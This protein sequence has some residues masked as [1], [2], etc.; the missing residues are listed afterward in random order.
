MTFIVPIPQSYIDTN[1][2]WT[3]ASGL[4]YIGISTNTTGYNYIIISI[5]TDK[6]SIP[7]GIKIFANDEGETPYVYYSDNYQANTLYCRSFKIAKKYYYINYTLESATTTLNLTSRLTTAYQVDTINNNPSVFDYS[8][9]FTLDAFGKVRVTNPN[10]LMDL[11]FYGQIG[12]ET[13]FLNNTVLLCSDSSG[14]FS[15][16]TSGNGYLTIRGTNTGHYISQSRKFVVYQP[17][18]SLL[19]LFSGQIMPNDGIANY[20]NNF[21]GKIGYYTN[22]PAFNSNNTI[23]Y[24]GLY[25]QYDS[26]GCSINLC[27]KGSITQYFQAQWNLDTMDGLGPSGINL[28]F[29]NAQ[30][31]VIDLEWLGV[32]RIRFGYYVYGIIH[33]CHQITNINQLIEPYI[34]NIN[35]PVRYELIGIGISGTTAT[36]KQICYTVISEGGYNPIGKPFGFNS[37][38]PISATTTETPVLALRGGSSNYFHQNIIP[39]SID[40]IDTVNNNVNLWRIRIYQDADTSNAGVTSWINVN[41][42]Y[43]VSQYSSTFSGW[44]VG[45]SIVVSQ[46]IFSGKGNVL[47]SDLSDV[48]TSQILHITANIN[49][50]SDIIVLTCQVL[51]GTSATIYS[52]ITV[53]EHY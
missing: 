41:T 52:S 26:S 38:T 30:L 31:F 17:G 19:V 11:N 25:Y 44:G 36:I 16:D 12:G 7:N 37:N 53:D 9:E 10:T 6:N 8:K 28:N 46:G 39:K 2:T 15:A 51:S 20:V 4:T 49:L 24:N 32:G 13:Q 1:N 5:K 34:S 23:P 40:L 14:T 50:T 22:Y 29:F 35:L 47:L 45:N 48:F 33:Y 43:S 3:N 18:K 42:N 21:I 27:N